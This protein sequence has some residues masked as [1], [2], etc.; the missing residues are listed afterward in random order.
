VGRGSDDAAADKAAQESLSATLS[1]ILKGLIP[2]ALAAEGYEADFGNATDRA[3]SEAAFHAAKDLLRL[4]KHQNDD[5]DGCKLTGYL[6]FWIRKLKPL[7]EATYSGKGNKLDINER[8]ALWVMFA[9]FTQLLAEGSIAGGA[10]A[11]ALAKKLKEDR[12]LFEYLVYSTRFRTFGPHHYA[13]ILKL[14]TAL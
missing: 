13:M 7:P 4:Q 11:A 5:I 1:A 9:L 14:I 8:L 6:C 2:K 10:A 12:D 3:I